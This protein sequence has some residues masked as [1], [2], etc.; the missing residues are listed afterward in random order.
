MGTAAGFRMELYG[1][2]WN[3][4]VGNSFAGIVVYV[5]ET[6]LCKRR[7]GIGFYCVAVVLTGDVYTAGLHIFTGVVS[8]AVTV[9]KLAGFAAAGQG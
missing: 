7:Q 4:C 9:F 3:I 6:E 1:E 2:G 8:A 5:D